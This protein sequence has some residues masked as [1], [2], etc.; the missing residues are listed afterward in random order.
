M[1]CRVVFVRL[2]KLVLV[3]RIVVF[4]S[5]RRVILVSFI[6]FVVSFSL[7]LVVALLSLLCWRVLLGVF[8]LELFVV[9]VWFF[10]LLALFFLLIALLLLLFLHFKLFRR[11]YFVNCR[12]ERSNLDLW[13]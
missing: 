6:S 10:H 7:P 13:F 12:G 2:V 5:L 4:G 11:L 1:S 9:L 3:L 8:A